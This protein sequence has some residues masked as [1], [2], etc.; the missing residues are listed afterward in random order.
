MSTPAPDLR[1]LGRSVELDAALALSECSGDPVGS[2]LF[3][4]RP[5]G[6]LLVVETTTRVR[7]VTGP[8]ENQS[9]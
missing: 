8:P 4:E 6:T 7:A 3:V 9:P 1:E 5:D 2:L